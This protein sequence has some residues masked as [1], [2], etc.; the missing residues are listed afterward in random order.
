MAK[1]FTFPLPPDVS[2][3]GPLELKRKISVAQ[4]AEFNDLHP[5]TFRRNYGHLIKRISRRRQAV[6]LRD[7]IELPPPKPG[8]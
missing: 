5:D 3:L 7:A 8:A 1:H 6:E 2:S 4:A